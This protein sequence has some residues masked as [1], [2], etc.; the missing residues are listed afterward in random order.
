MTRAMAWPVAPS[1]G[2]ASPGASRNRST[3]RWKLRASTWITCAGTLRICHPGDPSTQGTWHPGT[4]VPPCPP[5]AIPALSCAL[6]LL[7]PHGAH[8]PMPIPCPPTSPRPAPVSL[9]P[10]VPI[11]PPCPHAHLC[12]KVTSTPSRLCAI[13]MPNSGVIWRARS[14]CARSSCGHRHR[15]AWGHGHQPTVP[16]GHG[17]HPGILWGTSHPTIPLGHLGIPPSLWGTRTP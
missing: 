2:V 8:A 1:G 11:S 15:W 14:T 9:C 5:M 13:S 12:R 17:H 6:W 7:Y 16:W 3:F 10:H 4:T